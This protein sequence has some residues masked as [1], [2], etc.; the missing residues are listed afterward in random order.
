[1]GRFDESLTE[2]TRADELSPRS[3]VI[4]LALGYRSYY[5]RQYSQA[6][7]QCLKTLAMDGAF[8]S[9]HGFLGRAY[10]QK[11]SYPEATAAFRKALQ[12]SD[13]DTNDLAALG[14]ALAASHQPVEAR[15]ILEQL[16]ERSQQTY[17]Q[18]MWLAVIY[19]ALD[20]K[21]QAFDWIQKAYDDRSAWL[22]YL[23]VDPL[24]D[25][26]RQDPRFTVLLRRVGLN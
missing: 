10:L 5:A 9:A 16:K 26:V 6:I 13:G 4:N 20:N 7:E 1:L 17:V 14:L 15:K 3:P 19:I 22:V 11:A 18:P 24:F 2:M 8:T 21:D 23:K 25:S 12:L